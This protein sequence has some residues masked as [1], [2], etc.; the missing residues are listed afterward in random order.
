[1]WICLTT[2][3]YEGATLPEVCD[4]YGIDFEIIDLDTN[5][6]VGERTWKQLVQSTLTPTKG[7]KLPRGPYTIEGIEV[8]FINID[9]DF[10][11]PMGLAVTAIETATPFNH[12]LNVKQVNDYTVEQWYVGTLAQ[13]VAYVN[14]VDSAQNYQ[15]GTLAWATPFESA[16]ESGL[17]AVPKHPNFTDS[18]MQLIQEQLPEGW[19][20]SDQLP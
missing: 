7:Y 11:H 2:A 9:I 15:S 4:Y 17:Y 12:I 5:E 1:M 19:H 6:V 13:T 3:T 14:R 8:W 10:T 18:E 16:T 20:P